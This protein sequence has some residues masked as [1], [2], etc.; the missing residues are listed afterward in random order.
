MDTI[1][2]FIEEFKDFP[3][4]KLDTDSKTYIAIVYIYKSE[5]KPFIDIINEGIIHSWE[6]PKQLH[7]WLEAYEK[8]GGD[9]ARLCIKQALGIK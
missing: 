6:I 9:N 3:W 8:R 5:D 7:K 1:N 2:H 4:E